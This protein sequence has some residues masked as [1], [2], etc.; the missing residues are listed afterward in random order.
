M[1]RIPDVG[2]PWLDAGIVAFSTISSDN[3]SE[4]LYLTDRGE[5][6]KWYPADFITESFP[7][8]FKNWFY[9]LLAMSTVLENSEPFK[10]VLGHATLFGEDGRPM[11]KSWGN[12]IEF[13]EGADKI[14]VDVMRWMYVHQNPA[15]NLLFG[16][17]IADE[18]RRRFHLTLW[19]VYN[20]FI[21]YA[22]LDVWRPNKKKVILSPLDKWILAR[23][24]QV[25]EDVTDFLEKYD[26]LSASES[27]ETFV[28][29]LSLWY[30]RRS[31]ERVGPVSE[32]ESDKE[33]FYQTTYTVLTDL[34]KILAPFTPFLSEVI[35]T[36]LTKE[37]S[38]H[39]AAWPTAKDKVDEKL[40]IDMVNIRAT[41]EK[42]HAIRKEKK[43]PVRQPL[44]ELKTIGLF[45]TP[46]KDLF[47]YLMDEV[48]VKKWSYKKGKE[49]KNILD[50]KITSELEEESKARELIRKIQEERRSLGMKLTQRAKITSP[51]LP[52]DKKLVQRVKTKTLA[53]GLEKGDFKVRPL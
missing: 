8:Q 45:D 34:S 35:Y 9:S 29:D 12:A 21:S 6:R 10:T 18:T 44:A 49:S 3:K 36:N 32:S 37:E 42:V 50:T 16:Y 13:N 24:S 47:R 15:E 11:H 30:V 28:D 27:I 52:K 1:E 4:P 23:L 5:W 20:F 48:N 31:R 19:N 41:V 53:S 43:I 2:N 22:N 17:H 51:W 46:A 25:T 39:L 38:V 40:I 7:G 26:A 14:G 33:A